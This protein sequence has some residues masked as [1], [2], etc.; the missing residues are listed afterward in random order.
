ML[1]GV[2]VTEGVFVGVTDS[3]GV[4]PVEYDE[5][6]MSQPGQLDREVGVLVGVTDIVGVLVGV[7]DIVGVLVE[8]L[9]VVGV[10]VG[11]RLGV[12]VTDGVIVDVFVTEGVIVG[13]TDSVGVIPVEYD[14][15]D[16]SQPGQLGIEDIV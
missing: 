14:E 13:V 3:V 6:D 11:V 12:L 5:P 7:T 10:L 9:V 8:V 16:M 4:I 15:P 2:F 1:V